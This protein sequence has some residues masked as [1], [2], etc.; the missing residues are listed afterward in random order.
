M[1]AV[2]NEKP[3][4]VVERPCPALPG[5]L[6]A[7]ARI[8]PKRADIL[9]LLPKGG[10]FVEIGVALGDYSATIMQICQPDMFVGLDVFTVH[11]TQ[12]LWGKPT[13]EVLKGKTHEEFYRDRFKKLI[14]AGRMNVIAGDTSEAL[15]TM[16]DGSI[17]IAYVDGDHAYDF[18][19]NQLVILNSKVKPNGWIIL[20]DYTMGNIENRMF[21][22]FGVIQATHEFMMAHGWEMIYLALHS[23]M[24][25]DVAIRR[26][27]RTPDRG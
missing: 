7:N 12:K 3:A 10:V 5:R 26:V 1:L 22:R 15:A 11:E 16:A 27:A 18:V 17:D 8:L 24:Y 6:L 25:C 19:K 2:K 4:A 23:H 9:P 21:K 20:N 14:E 13:V